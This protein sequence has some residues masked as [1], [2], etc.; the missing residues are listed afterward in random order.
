MSSVNLEPSWLAA[1]ADEFQQDYMRELSAFLKEES[2]A[3]KV[4]YPPAKFIFNALDSTPIN[5]VKI[6]ILGQDPYHGPNQAHGLS[7]SVP[8]GVRP[9][10]SLINIFKAIDNDLGI[11]P[12][13]HG[14]LQSWAEQGVLLLNSVLTVEHKQAGSHAAKGWERFTDKIVEALNQQREGLVFM[15]WGAYAQKKGA[16]IDSNKHLVLKA[17]HPSPLSAHRGFLTCGHFSKANDYLEKNNIEKV[18]WRV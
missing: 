1:L 15:L 8:Q 2:N 11:T 9:P 5:K 17:V 7:F 16:I 13:G 12:P 14:C 18:D 3:G 4:I 6:V 10:P